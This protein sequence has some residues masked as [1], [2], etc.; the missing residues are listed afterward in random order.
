[1]NNPKD[2]V[3]VRIKV[4]GVFAGSAVANR[5]RSDL[6]A[7]GYGD[8]HHGFEFPVPA[9]V[10]KIWAVEATIEGAAV[11]LTHSSDHISFEDSDLLLPP[12]W[13]TGSRHFQPSLFVLGAAKCGTTALHDYLGQHPDIFMSDPK[14]P[15]YFEAEY[16][17]GT[18]FYFNRYFN[19]WAGERIV[20]EA[21]H[22]NLYLPYVPERI[23]TY[24]PD[25]KLVAILRN[26]VERAVSHWWHWYSRGQ[27]VLPLHEALRVDDERIRSNVGFRNAEEIQTYSTNLDPYGQGIYRT[28]LD[29]GYYCEQLERY[30]SAFGR[31]R[32]FVIL[33]EDFVSKPREIMASLFAFL[34]CSTDIAEKIVLGGI[35]ESAP[36]ML[37]HLDHGLKSWLLD[38]YRP[39]NGKL[40]SF[41]G[42]G[43]A[44]WERPFQAG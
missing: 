22:R 18:N 9:G 40:E 36:G 30:A 12:E 25:A 41:L 13:G 5:F 37:E 16:D 23:R 35:N 14:E 21:R 4:N 2:S 34:D 32:L 26:P 33:Y 29:T 6:V 19:K 1:M 31:S 10:P 11:P 3:R 43:L 17:L 8:G 38:H 15:F 27:E 24:N 39:H 28:C 42:K 7:A 44:A 20:G